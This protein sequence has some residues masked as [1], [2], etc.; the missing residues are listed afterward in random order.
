MAVWPYNTQRWQRLRR[1]KLRQQPTCEYCRPHTTTAATEVDHRQAIND[2][3]DPWAMS[4]LV[5]SCK[6][7]HSRKTRHVEQL[8]R[9]H[10]PVKGCDASGLPLDP[11]HP[12]AAPS[13]RK[14]S[15]TLR[16][17]DRRSTSTQT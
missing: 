6:P 7:C 12:W 8:Q 1:L 13:A 3:G 17:E 16:P 10:V 11:A 4:N 2:G 5:S 14:H 15:S 9:D